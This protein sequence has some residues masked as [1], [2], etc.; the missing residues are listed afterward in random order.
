MENKIKNKV[1]YAII[2]KSENKEW[3]EAVKEWK[4]E[5]CFE[6]T[7]RNRECICGKEHPQYKYKLVN[8]KNGKVIY[9][10][11]KKCIKKL[12]REELDREAE[13]Y[14][15]KM[16]LE[17]RMA[18]GDYLSISDEDLS[19]RVIKHMYDNGVFEGNEYNGQN[20]ERDYQFLIDMKN[21]K[22]KSAISEQEERKLKA[23]MVQMKKYLKK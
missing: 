6:D 3:K 4:I 12:G 17:H 5:N 15:Q 18:K 21:K 22:N 13:M 7:T 16:S 10:I 23:M 20:G 8:K 1:A 19:K 11:S 9:P 14:V 2:C